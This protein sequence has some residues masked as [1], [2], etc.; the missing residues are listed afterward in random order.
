MMKFITEEYLRDLYRKEAFETY[1]LKEGQRLTPGAYEYLSDK[2]IKLEE[3]ASKAKENVSGEIEAEVEN[4]NAGP[5]LN[6]RLCC[7]LKSVQSVFL[8]TGSE[9]L[10][11]D[12]ILAQKIINLGKKISNIRSAVNGKVSL[13]TI[14]CQSC[15]GIDHSNFTDE[16]GDCFEISEFHMQLKKGG[17]IL[18]MHMLRC[19]LEELKLEIADAYESD[20]VL[21]VE[22]TRNVNAI[23]N[24]LSQLI[25][26]A[27]G[28]EKC[29]RRS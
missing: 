6:K 25:C 11:D 24:S 4:R 23:I 7:K 21:K 12:I 20:D 8:V 10:K 27:V 28:G 29:Q 5:V 13:E 22:T 17:E 2:R 19:V 18:K 3:D 26:S 16:L 15:G 14:E 1:S 9:I